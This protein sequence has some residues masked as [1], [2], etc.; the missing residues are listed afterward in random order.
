MMDEFKPEGTP[1]EGDKVAPQTI[2]PIQPVAEE[3]QHAQVDQAQQQ[4]AE[5]TP[6]Q[7]QP[8][9]DPTPK[10]AEQV[11]RFK[12]MR[13]STE[14]L[15]RERDEA[16]RRLQEYERRAQEPDIDV[17]IDIKDDDLA[18]GKHLKKLRDEVKKLKAEQRQFQKQSYESNAEARIR[19]QFQ[20]FDKVAT[21]ENLQ[22]LSQMYPELA[23]S[24]NATNDIYDKAVSA[25]QLIK[26][27][28]IY[29]DEPFAAEKQ[30]AISN[31]QKP[32][33]LASISPQQ[34]E[35]PLSRANAFAGN[36]YKLTADM[37]EALR[38]EMEEASKRY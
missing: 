4:Q 3:P 25:Y 27:F 35:T 2:T 1:V 17:D 20:D 31:T 6:Q 7:R 11:R 5:A 21:V 10:D 34:G 28:G 29:E 22:V 23:K 14:R 18:E 8:S 12:A 19:A 36:N 30:Q 32:K 13:E 33:P 16:L 24:I 26:K 15:E 38:K 37:K 9:L